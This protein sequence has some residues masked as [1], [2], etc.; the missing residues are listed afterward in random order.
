MAPLPLQVPASTPD[1]SSPTGT[2]GHFHMELLLQRV[3]ATGSEQRG[4]HL[5]SGRILGRAPQQPTHAPR[6]LGAKSTL[7]ILLRLLIIHPRSTPGTPQDA[8]LL[9]ERSPGSAPEPSHQTGSGS[10][11]RLYCSPLTPTP[12]APSSLVSSFP[13]STEVSCS[14][15]P[16][17]LA[18]AMGHRDSKRQLDCN[19]T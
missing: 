9:L 11:L 10:D 12:S 15:L 4:R 6:P 14:L 17:L 19:L 1:N 18:A 8:S 5:L 16:T 13:F 2:S 7:C 3:G